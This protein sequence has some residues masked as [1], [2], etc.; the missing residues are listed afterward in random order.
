[1]KGVKG[2]KGEKVG[3][4]DGG[5]GGRGTGKKT[6]GGGAKKKQ[7]KTRKKRKWA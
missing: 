4:K 3:R 1:M 2:A 6:G 7:K 5:V